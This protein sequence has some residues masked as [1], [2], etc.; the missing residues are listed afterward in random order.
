M[1]H[2]ESSKRLAS[3]RNTRRETPT[4]NP[5]GPADTSQTKHQALPKGQNVKLYQ[6]R[7]RRG[8]AGANRKRHTM[9]NQESYPVTRPQLLQFRAPRGVTP[10]GSSRVEQEGDYFFF[11][12]AVDELQNGTM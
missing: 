1:L 10:K 5:I 3:P 6:R 8:L 4:L 12:T 2:G 7:R 9:V 11:P